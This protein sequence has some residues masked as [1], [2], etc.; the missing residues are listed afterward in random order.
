MRINLRKKI[1]IPSMIFVVAISCVIIHK[2]VNNYEF[3]NVKIISIKAKEYLAPNEDESLMYKNS[4]FIEKEQPTLTEETKKLISNYQKDQ[5]LDNYLKLRDEVIKNYD[6]VLERKEKKLAELIE[7]TKDKPN[8]DALVSEMQEIVQEMYITYWN[9]INSSM[10]RFTDSR[11]LKWKIQEASKYEYIPVMGAG[12]SIYVKR[13]QVTNK[14]YAEF[15]SDANHKAP[16][17]WTNGKY[18]TGEDDYPVNYVSYQDAVD[19]TNWLTKKDGT[20]TY[21][22]PTESEWELAA[23]HMPKDADFNAGNIK[24]GRTSVNEYVG[25]TRGAHGAIDFWGNVWEWTSTVRDTSDGINLLGVKGGSWKS[26]RTDCRTEHRKESRKAN[27]GYDDVGF[28]VIQVLNGKEPEQEAGL[29]TLDAPNVTTKKE[30]G[31]IIVSWNKVKDAVEYQ[32]FEYNKDTKLFKMLD[33]VTDTS[34]I[35]NNDPS[36]NKYIV[37]A[38]SYTAISDNVNPDGINQIKNDNTSST[39]NNIQ[40]ESSDNNYIYYIIGGIGIIAIVGGLLLLI[41]KKRDESNE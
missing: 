17:N 5:N 23:G 25:K 15:I 7:E 26:L 39:D 8:G 36:N 4:E 1:I 34:Y 29:Y 2:T 20:N 13:T 14:E 32:I 11:L 28:R 41:S 21:R 37:Q 24:D 9:R 22:L 30:N 3:Q 38:L 16:S 19:Y 10:L 18:S 31:N 27:D 40:E 6:A 35:I 12:D 33:R